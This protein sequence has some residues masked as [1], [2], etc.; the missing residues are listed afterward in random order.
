[1]WSTGNERFRVGLRGLEWEALRTGNERVRV[2]C[3]EGWE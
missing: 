1:M 3:I 2:G